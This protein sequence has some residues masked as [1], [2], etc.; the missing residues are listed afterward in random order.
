L[1][2]HSSSY[3][4][5]ARRI[6]QPAEKAS[7]AR[8]S[9]VRGELRAPT[10]VVAQASAQAFGRGPTRYHSKK[11]L[12][13]MSTV[14]V[15]KCSDGNLYTGCT[16]NLNDRLGRHEAGYV[17]ATKARLPM[18]LMTYIVFNDQ[19]KAFNFERYLKSGSGR[20]FLN[21]RLV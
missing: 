15:L 17:P 11:P 20:A 12:P 9:F 7:F 18:T 6:R 14:Y 3:P 13:D 21:K 10:L 8:E 5:F 19:Y 2:R 4:D 1:V 16:E